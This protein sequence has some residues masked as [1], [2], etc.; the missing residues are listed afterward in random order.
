MNKRPNMNSATQSSRTGSENY[1]KN[2]NVQN[3]QTGKSQR[4]EIVQLYPFSKQN[5][6]QSLAN[7]MPT[8]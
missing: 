8:I 7:S 2:Q 5:L 6:G 3:T 4:T 1:K